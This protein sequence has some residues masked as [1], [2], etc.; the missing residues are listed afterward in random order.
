MC[1]IRTT[2]A[3]RIRDLAAANGLSIVQLARVSG[4]PQSTIYSILDGK[5]SNPSLTVVAKICDGLHITVF[6]FFNADAFCV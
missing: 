1:N 4:V 3:K 2:T 5:S 6:E